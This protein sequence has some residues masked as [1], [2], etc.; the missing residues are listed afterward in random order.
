MML[1]QP[2]V[3]AFGLMLFAAIG[4][5]SSFLLWIVPP[6]RRWTLRWPLF[7]IAAFGALLIAGAVVLSWLKLDP[8]FF[9]PMI[10]S[11]FALEIVCGAA[12]VVRA[13][14]WYLWAYWR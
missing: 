12:L 6:I 8:Y 4:F 13:F 14:E 10:M 1:A 5:C 9:S 3:A 7:W 2:L 11:G